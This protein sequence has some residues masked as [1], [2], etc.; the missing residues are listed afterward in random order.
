[1]GRLKMRKGLSLHFS[2]ISLHRS[3]KAINSS[4]LFGI[5]AIEC[6]EEK[7]SEM[8]FA[9]VKYSCYSVSFMQRVKFFVVTR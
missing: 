9:G 8:V 4:I 3:T 5:F 1:M 2:Q 7:L 6:G